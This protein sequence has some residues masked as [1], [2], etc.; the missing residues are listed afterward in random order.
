MSEAGESDPERLAETR[1][2]IANIFQLLST[3]TRMRLQRADDPDSRRH[4][5]W[6]L[7]MV[8]AMGLLQHRLHSPGGE[9]FANYLEDMA[10]YWR[11]RRADRP[12][13]I[14]LSAQ[15][16]RVPENHASALALIVNELVLNAIAHG[17]PGD[18]A[19][20]VRIELE[21]LGDRAVLSVSDDGQGYDPTATESGRLGLWLVNG[22][23]AQVRGTL[24]TTIH[25]GVRA[26]L[27]FPVAA[28]SA[29]AIDQD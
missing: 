26:R 23:S 22:L 24:A 19:G 13:E 9:D 1:H 5:A 14:E 18:R 11:R 3:L 15:P 16:L 20:V 25:G 27:E 2:K 21:R 7:E 12:I 29:K 17:F 28:Q 6:M 8:S 4:L 10:G